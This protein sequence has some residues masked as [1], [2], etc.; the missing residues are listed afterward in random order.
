M[1]AVLAI[2]QP[3]STPSAETPYAVVTNPVRQNLYNTHTATQ[4][5]VQGS[6]L[7][8]DSLDFKTVVSLLLC[9]GCPDLDWWVGPIEGAGTWDGTALSYVYIYFFILVSL[10]QIKSKPKQ[11]PFSGPSFSEHRAT[12]CSAVLF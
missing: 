10:N 12:Q 1:N 11:V 4:W 3:N 6:A 8:N 9:Q 5:T 2:K 7:L